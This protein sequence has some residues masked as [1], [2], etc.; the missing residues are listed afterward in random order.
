M[1]SSF[2]NKLVIIG[3]KDLINKFYDIVKLEKQGTSAIGIID[4]NK[5]IPMPKNIS[6][7]DKDVD[8]IH[9]SLYDWLKEN[10]GP[11]SLPS[12]ISEKNNTKDNIW[13][14]TYKGNC[15]NIIKKLSEM[16]PKLEFNYYY[17]DFNNLGN[18]VG[19]YI[20][21]NNLLKTNIIFKDGSNGAFKF[22][23][24]LEECTPKDLSLIY[25]KDIDNY[26]YIFYNKD[27]IF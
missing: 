20:F 12:F 14:K 13:F 2:V 21:K 8:F 22:I 17:Y 11:N 6:D 24:E 1:M 19:K 27:I 5:I 23:F 10:W 25:N 7:M 26:E 18:N 16:F 4:F 9:M 15:I 3:E